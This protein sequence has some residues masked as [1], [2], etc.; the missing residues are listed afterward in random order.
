MKLFSVSQ[1]LQEMSG[2]AQVCP[3]CGYGP[4]HKTHT[5]RANA[6]TPADKWR[7]KNTPLPGYPLASGA[8]PAAGGAPAV[9]APAAPRSTP[10]ASPVARAP[11]AAPVPTPTVV[12]TP[13]A[14]RA[15]PPAASTPGDLRQKITQWLERHSVANFTVNEDNTVNVAGD[16]R[17]TG[18]MFKRIPFKFGKVDGDFTLSGG[19]LE[20]LEGCPTSVGGDV[21]IIHTVITSLVGLPNEIGGNC[22]V[23]HNKKVA[24]LEGIPAKINGSFSA[25]GC[26][27]LVSL[28]GIHKILKEVDGDLDF[29]SS[30]VK[31][32]VLGVLMIRGVTDVKL[33]EAKVAE[34]INKH[35]K[36]EDKDLHAAQEELIDAGFTAAA[37]P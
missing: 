21:F 10:T 16:C 34:I 8:A 3:K 37:K 25:E 13:G 6:A 31:E 26:T 35:L 19:H 1:T 28:K 15:T 30:G 33:P 24:S 18:L 12:H 9:S 14:T 17:L 2:P 4:I 11:A 27:S 23:A 29:S 5:Y 20:T 22:S 32:N 7:C 36:S